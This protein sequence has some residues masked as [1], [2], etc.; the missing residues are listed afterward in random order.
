VPVAD[1]ILCVDCGSTCHRLPIDP[2]A[3][4]WQAGDVVT[5]RCSGCVDMWYVEVDQ[6]DVD[7]GLSPD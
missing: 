1:T 2:P 7:E 6:D 3:H 5:Y 4:G